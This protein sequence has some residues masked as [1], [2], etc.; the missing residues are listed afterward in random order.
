[1]IDPPPLAQRRVERT[2]IWGTPDQLI[3]AL[4]CVLDNNRQRRQSGS[5]RLDDLRSAPGRG[6]A[7]RGERIRKGDRPD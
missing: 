6:G 1:M 7:A 4:K 5:R 3:E 2:C